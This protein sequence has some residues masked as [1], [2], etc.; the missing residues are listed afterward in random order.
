MKTG[1]QKTPVAVTRG[2]NTGFFSQKVDW[3][4][5]TFKSG[6]P[7][8]LPVILGQSFVETKAFHGY[9]VGSLYEDGRTLMSNPSRPE[10]GVHLT[11]DGEAC[12]RCPI[13]P[14][15]LVKALLKAKF[16]FTRIDIAIDF[17]NCN[18][19]PEQATEEIHEGRIKTRAQQFPFW[20]NANGK[21]HT[22]YI[23]KKASES[24]LRI[25][26][27]A[28]EMGI[29][30]DHARVELVV[31][32]TKAQAA[33]YAIDRN[34]DFRGM[35]LSFADF[36]EW[37]EWRTAMEVSEVKLPT[38]RKQTNTE[39]W[40]IE[41]VAPALA[42]LMVLADN[43]IFYEQFKE[44]VLQNCILLSNNRQTVH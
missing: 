44:A 7:V 10:M 40:L 5:G 29:E 18:L 27:K 9:T 32:H 19:L 22:Q 11:W 21:G 24:Y 13:N 20:G 4:E 2:S 43:T 34:A 8:T 41:A 28:A 35:V 14:V 15:D 33:A 12:G 36:T 3:L 23:G 25:Y 30:Q 38:V 17:I 26:D 42:R 6:V 31:R 1:P 39:K 16:T 37:G